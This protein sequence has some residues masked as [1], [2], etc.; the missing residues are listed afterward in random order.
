NQKDVAALASIQKTN[1]EN[2]LAGVENGTFSG[3]VILPKDY[4]NAIMSGD[5]VRGKV[6]LSDGSFIDASLIRRVARTGEGLIRMGQYG[7]FAGA[8]VVAR[9]SET[10]E[11]YDMYILQI[12]DSLMYEAS[13]ANERY[14]TEETT[15]YSSSTLP[16]A[17]HTVLL[18]LLSLASLSTLFFYRS[19]TADLSPA[20]TARLR[21]SGVDAASFLV[22]K[23]LY[24]LLFRLFLCGTL[25]LVISRFF[26]LTLTPLSVLSFLVALLLSS[27]LDTFM[28]VCLAGNRFGIVLL[29]LFFLVQMFFAGGILPLHYLADPIAA[30]GRVLPLGLAFRLSASL[31]GASLAPISALLLMLWL[32]PLCLLGV[33]RQKC[34]CTEGGKSV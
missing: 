18:M 33:H 27:A 6:L 14:V 22:P 7:V 10:R 8:S 31:L 28:A 13:T 12:N 11:I 3:A 19:T 2:A 9:N 32:I 20:L 34:I 5:F 16:L 29:S 26:T 24:N 1:Y 15:A 4:L 21:A 25:L 30:I 23:I 17:E